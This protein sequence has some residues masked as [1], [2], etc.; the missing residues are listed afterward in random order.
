MRCRFT[1]CLMVMLFNH[2]LKQILIFLVKRI[3]HYHFHVAVLDKR[4]VYIPHVSY[5]SAHPCRKV[6]S[7]LTKYNHGSACHILAAV[8][9]HALDN[10]VHSRVAHSKS[11]SGQ[12]FDERLA[13]SSAIESYVAHDHIFCS[14]ELT[15]SWRIKNQPRT[16]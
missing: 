12:T 7:G 6:P 10:Y 4:F 16:G 14:I 13:R 1:F 11:L 8:I 2:F 15:L 5:T 3:Q 9:A